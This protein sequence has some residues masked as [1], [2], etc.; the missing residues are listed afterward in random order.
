MRSIRVKEVNLERGFPTVDMAIRE[1]I[2]QLG[3]YKRLGYRAIILIHGYGSTGT[4]GKIKNAVRAKLKEKSLSGIVKRFCGGE[5]WAYNKRVMLDNCKQLRDFE[6]RVSG[7][8]GV[9]VVI[10]K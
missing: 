1:M 5:E 3:T 9:T 8:P 10:L 6:V 7:N 2:S 4:G